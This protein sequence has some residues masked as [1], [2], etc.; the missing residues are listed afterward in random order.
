MTLWVP[1]MSSA[2]REQKSDLAIEV[3]I[4]DGWHLFRVSQGKEVV[5]WSP[6]TLSRTHTVKRCLAD[7]PFTPETSE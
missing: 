1:R 7:Q 4:R 3:V 5:P 2:C 6:P